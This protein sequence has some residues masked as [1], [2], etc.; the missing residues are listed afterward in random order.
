MKEISKEYAAALFALGCECGEE[1]QLMRELEHIAR[2]LEQHPDYM[3]LISSPAV[4][5]G[6]RLA[7]LGALL[8]GRFCDHT[9]SFIQLLCEKGRVRSFFEC[10]QEYRHLLDAKMAMAVARVS[11]A[12]ELTEQE[13][14]AL[15]KKLEHMSGATVTLECTVDPSLLGG[16]IV[17]MDG[18]VMDGSLRRRLQQ[19]KEVM[20]T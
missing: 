4:P 17:E 3:A 16:V 19:V 15:I 11:S 18:R 13:K 10:V 7:V 5:L 20:N 6:E 12:I 9:V 1:Q 2:L 14:H 8:E